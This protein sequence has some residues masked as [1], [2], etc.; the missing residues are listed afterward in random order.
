MRAGL[1]TPFTGSVASPRSFLTTRPS[2]LLERLAIVACRDTLPGSL[3]R[4]GEV[5]RTR[6]AHRPRPTSTPP[7]VDPDLHAGGSTARSHQIAGREAE[8][9]TALLG[10][11]ARE[12][13]PIRSRR[14]L[15][16]PADAAAPRDG[17]S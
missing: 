3:G 1:P 14:V 4:G 11:G 9:A 15:L 6:P 13:E 10:S 12:A 16:G 5:E 2:A 7:H 8:D 17:C